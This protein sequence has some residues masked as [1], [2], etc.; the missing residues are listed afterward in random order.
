MVQCIPF[1]QFIFLQVRWLTIKHKPGINIQQ[2]I[3]VSVNYSKQEM[4]SDQPATEMDQTYTGFIPASSNL[5]VRF[6]MPCRWLRFRN[7]KSYELINSM[8]S[9]TFQ[10]S[11]LM[12]KQFSL[13]LWL[14]R[15][16]WSELL[17]L[18]FPPQPREM[19]NSIIQQIRQADGLTTWFGKC[20]YNTINKGVT[21][22]GNCLPANSISFTNKKPL[23]S[24]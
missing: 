11:K 5:T 4:N 15:P 19:G 12:G 3:P 21:Q 24:T 10:I 1:G 2:L 14:H 9:I 17:F 16:H 8:S 23:L 13:A 7:K 20:S 6:N 22:M 18:S